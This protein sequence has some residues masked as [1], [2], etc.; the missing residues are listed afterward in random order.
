[1]QHRK[2]LE[3]EGK[4]QEELEKHALEDTWKVPMHCGVG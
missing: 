3:Y 2:K 1:M 4:E